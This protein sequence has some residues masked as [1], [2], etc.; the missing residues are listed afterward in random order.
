MLKQVIVKHD[1]G[2]VFVVDDNALSIAYITSDNKLFL[3]E[4]T[5]VKHEQALMTG[6]TPDERITA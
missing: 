2:K 1:K 4:Q 3:D 6:G 5:A